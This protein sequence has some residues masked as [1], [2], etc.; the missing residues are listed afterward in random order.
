MVHGFG[1]YALR[2]IVLL[3]DSDSHLGN[4]GLLRVW[5][6]IESLKKVKIHV[7]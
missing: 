1:F 6:F 4:V 2:Q 3:C 7:A 5:D